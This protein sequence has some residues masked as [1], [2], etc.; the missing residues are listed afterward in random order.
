MKKYWLFFVLAVSCPI[1]TLFT[2]EENQPVKSDQ[3]KNEKLNTPK[4]IRLPKEIYNSIAEWANEEFIRRNLNHTN[5]KK[6]RI[7]NANLNSK[8][9]GNE[10]AKTFEE[11][12]KDWTFNMSG[13]EIIS[14]LNQIN[15]SLAFC[16][17]MKKR[18]EALNST[19][20]ALTKH[21]P[22]AF[23][24]NSS[25]W[26]TLN[27][28]LKKVDSYIKENWTFYN[29]LLPN[30]KTTK[31]ILTQ[32]NNNPFPDNFDKLLMHYK[33]FFPNEQSVSLAIL[34]EYIKCLVGNLEKQINISKIS[35]L[36][37]L[38]SYYDKYSPLATKK[39]DEIK[40]Y[41]DEMKQDTETNFETLKKLLDD[42]TFIGN[43]LALINPRNLEKN[44]EGKLLYP[45]G[46]K[47]NTKEEEK[48]LDSKFISNL[49]KEVL[50]SFLLKKTKYFRKGLDLLRKKMAEYKQE[51]Y[52]RNNK[53][54][55]LSDSHDNSIYPLFPERRTLVQEMLTDV[56]SLKQ[57]I[58]DI[59]KIITYNP[60]TL[61]DEKSYITTIN[62]VLAEKKKILTAEM[63]FIRLVEQQAQKYI[64][65]GFCPVCHN[66]ASYKCR[67]CKRVFYCSKVHQRYHWP[68]HRQQCTPLPEH[69]KKPLYFIANLIN[70]KEIA[71][72]DN[73]E[74]NL[75]PNEN[76]L[77]PHEAKF[78]F[79]NR[80]YTLKIN[81][82]HGP[83]F[84]EFGG[85][86]Q[87]QVYFDDGAAREMINNQSQTPL[88][89]NEKAKIAFSHLAYTFLQNKGGK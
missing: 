2:M 31:R 66:L 85:K 1:A 58:Q 30:I 74:N 51:V 22:S 52:T 73:N 29:K 46:K 62:E 89:S 70:N 84:L 41:S 35:L 14:T 32:V 3:Q 42:I 39:L 27:I 86:M 24:S 48:S 59:R 23:L 61:N 9:T 8:V 7:N 82:S 43:N 47:R 45:K 68:E 34:K 20:N 81:I 33:S 21:G 44:N 15:E 55:Q 78:I 75:I 6:R 49:K 50:D 56:D 71:F 13:E 5:K 53:N 36:M 76:N 88:D 40:K 63:N 72:F 16:T 25:I 60:K 11:L 28:E 79:E 64:Q 10:G 12:R 17:E 87:Y 83:V 54:N 19:T 69:K 18:L 67:N 37:F 4:K 57:K 38:H 65:K 80:S 77:I 26:D